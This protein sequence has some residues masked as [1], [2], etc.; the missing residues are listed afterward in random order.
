MT[1]LPDRHALLVTGPIG[2]RFEPRMR[3]LL[4]SHPDTRLVVM[5]GPG[6]M[7]GQALRAASLLNERGVTVRVEGKC[8]S[9]CAL[10]WAAAH[11]RE[12]TDDSRL[13]L[14]RSSLP[15][16][17]ALPELM[18]QQIIA[19]NDRET[20]DVLRAAG[21]PE[22]VIAQ[23]AA[24]PP[25]SMAWFSATELKQQGVPFVL[26]DAGQTEAI[27]SRVA[28]VPAA[29]TVDAAP[30]VIATAADAVRTEGDRLRGQS[31]T[32]VRRGLIGW[33]A[34]VLGSDCARPAEDPAQAERVPVA[35]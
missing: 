15:G 2:D 30:I 8:A 6:G 13:G 12:M 7:R 29:A 11:S 3:G 26:Q 27:A 9:A 24:T 31:R 22:P 35:R 21:F 4:A 14:H 20:D 25:T 19:R 16:A 10:L 17:E 23:G 1:V 33:I 28:D 18:R 34:C 5:R 32:P